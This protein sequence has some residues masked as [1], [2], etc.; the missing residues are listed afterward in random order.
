MPAA[1]HSEERSNMAD[2]IIGITFANVQVTNGSANIPRISGTLLVDYTTGKVTGRLV[3]VGIGGVNYFYQDFSLTSSGTTYSLSSPSASGAGSLD[4]SYSGTQPPGLST[5]N[6]SNVTGAF[7]AL[8]PGSNE[9]S[10]QIINPYPNNL[11]YSSTASP[12]FNFIDY[13][14]FEASFPD[15]IAAFGLN[16]QEMQA[17]YLTFE[18]TEKR[19]ETF[20][21]LDYVASSPALIKADASAGSLQAIQDDGAKQYI[22]QGFAQGDVTTFNGLDYIASYSDLINAFGANGDAGAL[23]YIENGHNE[24]RVAT[25]DGLDYIASYG[26]LI[27]AFGAN[28]QAGAAHFI[29]YGHN[30]GRTTTFDGLSYIADYTDLMNAFGANNDAGA[31]HYITNGSQEGRSK[32]FT[33]HDASGTFS[34]AAAVTQYEKDWSTTAHFGNNDDAFFTAYIDT[35][36][37]SGGKFLG[38]G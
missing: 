26:D 21:G 25:F 10:E 35:Y 28:E 3:S 1:K 13:Y 2:N 30:E 36:K 6:L 14:N 37:S 8:V 33:Y 16:Q 9:L 7:T 22:S 19:I 11:A 18:P 34:G 38:Q 23:H 27:H 32:Q 5:I 17:W 15:L 12:P 29:T 24:G 4:F 31:S 20:D